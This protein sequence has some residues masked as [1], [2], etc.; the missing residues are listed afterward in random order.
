MAV[1]LAYKRFSD[2]HEELIRNAIINGINF[3]SF[4]D[5]LAVSDT[6]AVW[7]ASYAPRSAN[8]MESSGSSFVTLVIP[9]LLFEDATVQRP[10]GSVNKPPL[11]EHPY[12]SKK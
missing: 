2:G 1:L 12:F 3:G 4:K 11:S 7:S 10:T 8:P 6:P 5:I 9:S